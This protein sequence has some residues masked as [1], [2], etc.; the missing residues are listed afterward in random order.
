MTGQLWSLSLLRMI[1][2][3]V[4]ESIFSGSRH[5]ASDFTSMDIQFGITQLILNVCFYA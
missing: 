3:W 2:Q 4:S 5:V 1:L